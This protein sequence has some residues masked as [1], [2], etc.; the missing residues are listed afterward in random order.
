MEHSEIKRR[1]SRHEYSSPMSL[2]RMDYQ[3][4]SSYAEMKDY[5]KG[6]MSLVSSEKLVVG[7]LVYIEMNN[8]DEYAAGPE[9]RKSY[10]GN[11]KWIN[12]YSS[13]V[14]DAKD[15]YKCGIQYYVQ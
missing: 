14:A 3:D 5:G 9:K 2:Y 1:Y 12:P 11:V 15:F 7:Q 13:P 8:Y 4:Q 6:G 10:S